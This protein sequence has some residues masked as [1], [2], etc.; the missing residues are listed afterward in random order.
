MARTMS[1]DNDKLGLESSSSSSRRRTTALGPFARLFSQRLLLSKS[2]AASTASDGQAVNEEASTAR[3]HCTTAVF[4]QPPAT[5]ELQQRL[6]GH[7]N[8]YHQLQRRR[9]SVSSLVEQQQQRSGAE[10]SI[11]LNCPTPSFC[12]GQDVINSRRGT[13]S[14]QSWIRNSSEK[15]TTV[16]Q[17]NNSHSRSTSTEI[18]TNSSNSSTTT[19][20][21]CGGRQRKTAVYSRDFPIAE[22]RADSSSSAAEVSSEGVGHRLHSVENLINMYATML[23]DR[24]K[25]FSA[26]KSRAKS[27]GE[28]VIREPNVHCENECELDLI[29]CNL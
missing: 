13:N 4:H 17:V 16:T 20:T 29:Y 14:R 19:T 27:E 25:E 23:S 24:K 28:K 21:T 26:I 11:R 8:H 18:V 15:N 10:S 7:Y 1:S 5:R 6:F 9:R 3:T 22:F 2:R 12:G